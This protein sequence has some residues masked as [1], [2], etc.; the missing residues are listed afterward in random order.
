MNSRYQEMNDFLKFWRD[1][2]KENPNFELTE[3]I[4]Y[5]YLIRLGVDE[6]DKKVNLRKRSFDQNS[7]FEEWINYFSAYPN[8]KVFNSIDWRYFCQF[9]SNQNIGLAKNHIKVYVPLDY[10]HIEL[11]AKLIF[12]FLSKNNIPHHS[13]IGS[14]I[15]F[16]DIVIRLVN[17]DD[18]EKL[19]NFITLNQY[20]SEGLIS[21]NPFA[22]QKD[23]IALACDGSLSY[24]STISELVSNYINLMNKKNELNEIEIVSFYKYIMKVLSDDNLIKNIF[25]DSDDL[26]SN[27]KQVLELISSSFLPNFTYDDYI[28]HYKK[29]SNFNTNQK[30]F[31][32]NTAVRLT[33][34]KYNYEQCYSAIYKVINE[35]N[36]N[37]FTNDGNARINLM[38]ISPDEIREIVFNS[39]QNNKVTLPQACVDYVDGVL[40]ESVFTR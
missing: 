36:Y 10:D 27:R 6:R 26:L 8:I 19:I 35:R 34:S 40:N 15:R 25:N 28:S 5:N 9:I 3:T 21:P 4:V 38:A 37:L 7:M 16:D 23:G 14:E 2:L 29:Y 22:F 17:P 12:N 1:I 33:A 31:I 20:L 24:N 13:K 30:R 11:G 18:A 32:L 39:L